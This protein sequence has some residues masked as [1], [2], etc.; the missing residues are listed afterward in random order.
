MRLDLEPKRASSAR[1]E[2]PS[3]EL[4]YFTDP[5]CSWCWASEPIIKKIKAD[6]PGQVRIVYKMGGLLEAWENFFDSRNQIERAEQVAPHWVEVAERSGMPIDEGVWLEDPPSSTY[7]GCI[8]YK[9]AEAQDEAWAEVYLRRLREAVMTE[10]RNIS[11]ESVLFELAESLDFDM[12]RFK[13]DY[14]AGAREAF[15]ADLAET[16]RRGISGFPTMIG[17]NQDGAEIT[18]PGYRP[19]ADYESA[20][21]RLATSELYKMPLLA[22]ADFVA[23]HGH[24]AT[25]EVS[26]VYDLDHQAALS[27]LEELAIAGEVTKEPKAGGEFWRP[28]TP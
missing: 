6:Y 15:F 11:K 28:A 17:V 12:V 5:D 20:F 16:R 22:M 25:R 1:E 18:L 3:L 24:V 14:R 7:P 8:A 23:L 27:A 9:A 19:Y 10:R 4:L 13:A 21:K 2:R 26:V